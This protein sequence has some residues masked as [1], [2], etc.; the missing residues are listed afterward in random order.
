MKNFFSTLV[1]V[2]IGGVLLMC[3]PFLL[4]IIIGLTSSNDNTVTV[5]DNSVIVFDLTNS[6]SERAF[7]DPM[8]SI[9]AVMGGNVKTTVG[10]NDI[11]K[12]IDNAAT[13]DKIKGIYLTGSTCNAYYENIAEIRPHLAKFHESGKFIYFYDTSID[14]SSLYMASVADSIFVM[15]EGAV[16]LSGLAATIPFFKNACEKWG[17]DIQIIRHGKYKSAVE[18]FLM[19][20]MSDA[21]K[22]QTK[23]YLGVIWDEICKGIA[24][25]RNLT[26]DDVN[27]YTNRL[28]YT[29][30]QDAIEAKLIDG[31]MYK[32]EYISFLKQKLN[33]K[34]SDDIEAIDINKYAKSCNNDVNN[35]SENTIAVIYANGEIYNGSNESDYNNVY[36]NDLSYTIRQARRDDKVKA[37]VLRVNSPGGAVDA[38]EIIWREVKIAA[39]TKPV[40]VSMGSYAASGGYYIS[41][42]SSHIF[43]ENNTITGSIG[44]FGTIPCV[45][46]AANSLGVTFDAVYTNNDMLTSFEPLNDVQK[47]Y[48]QEF[49]EHG[50]ATFTKRVADGRGLSVEHVDSIGQG[51]VWAGADAIN[52]GLVD[53]IGS[54]EDAINY[55]ADKA[56]LDNYKLKSLPEIEDSFTLMMKKMG[57]NAKAF[58]G[59]S[60]FGE[61]Y[62]MVEK[63]KSQIDEPTVQARMEYD[64]ILK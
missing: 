43:A 44:I 60:L 9:N 48:M 36:G 57:M 25:G 20:H 59:E 7:D 19:D 35:D 54:L 16:S 26:T 31:T 21:S 14:Q 23:R 24:E 29:T 56:G 34:E 17:V 40:I 18:P 10:M 51:R 28:N 5:K 38:S 53:E 1:A 62:K 58:V 12:A 13:D 8:A 3:M 47:T 55:A 32:D 11:I 4:L 37:I 30:T 52:I 61:D 33:V 27:E 2:I 45:K 22:E 42:A 50:Y 46:R 6:V 49:I 41:C 63:I 39:E 15:P 64:I